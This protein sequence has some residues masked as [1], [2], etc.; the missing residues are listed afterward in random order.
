MVQN[1]DWLIPLLT[2]WMI[3]EHEHTLRYR[4][5]P[6]CRLSTQPQQWHL[7]SLHQSTKSPLNAWENRNGVSYFVFTFFNLKLDVVKKYFPGCRLIVKSKEAVDFFLIFKDFIRKGLQA[8]F[9]T[10]SHQLK[11]FCCRAKLSWSVLSI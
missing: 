3:S 1:M 5:I 4:H 7:W 6:G 8:Q 11:N 2:K 9:S 10:L